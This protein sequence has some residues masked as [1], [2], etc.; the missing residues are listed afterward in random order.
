MIEKETDV[1]KQLL[2]AGK[3]D[4]ALLAL[5]K[6]KYQAGLLEKSDAQLTNLEEMVNSIEFAQIEQKV[7]SGIKSGN[8]A[9][10]ELHKVMSV[11]DA[12]KIMLETEDAL[13]YQQEL[14]ELL[15]G[16]LS[17]D[18]MSEVEAELA[19]LVGG[20][21]P[22]KAA[23]A[24]DALADAPAAPDEPLPAGEEAK[25]VKEKKKAVAA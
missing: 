2:A 7:L 23:P 1:A 10:K 4:K 13:A 20:A 21:E 14:D 11:E 25:K 16:A 15:T 9:L 8:T 18:D 3:K 6:K 24:K 12:E 17:N 22:T 19:A 5:R